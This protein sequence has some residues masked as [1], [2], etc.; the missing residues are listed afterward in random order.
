MELA[1]KHNAALVYMGHG[2]EFYSTGIYSETEKEFNIQYPDVKTFIGVVE[3]YPGLDDLMEK[4]KEQK[5]KKVI[6]KPF[7]VVAGDHAIN[8]MAG[9]EPDSWKNV[10]NKEGIEVI[11][12]I[13]GL[14][15]ND[16]FAR[17][18][19]EHL[20]DAINDGEIILK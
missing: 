17:I 20:K 16:D 7:M 2:N 19:L 6:L 14:G 18:F 8:D 13:E 1:R 10:L 4:L 11:P 3:G 9:D 5:V 15:S 12:V